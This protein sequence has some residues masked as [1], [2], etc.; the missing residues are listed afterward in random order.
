[1]PSLLLY[2][3]GHAQPNPGT[4]WRGVNTMGSESLGGEHPGVG[5]IGSTLETAYH[6][7]C[8]WRSLDSSSNGASTYPPSPL[9]PLIGSQFEPQST[10]LGA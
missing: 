5:I 10:N 7:V 4:V 6:S 8:W 1:M 9:A 3:I 2:A